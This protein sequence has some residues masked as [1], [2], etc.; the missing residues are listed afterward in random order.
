MLF[1][2]QKCLFM[3]CLKSVKVQDKDLL[4]IK[5][6]TP[7][8]SECLIPV[9]VALGAIGLLSLLTGLSPFKPLANFLK[10]LNWKSGLIFT[11]T[12]VG[13]V[14]V[15]SFPRCVKHRSGLPVKDLQKEI[16][17]PTSTI[18]SLPKGKRQP[19]V[20]ITSRENEKEFINSIMKKERRLSSK[21]LYRLHDSLHP[22][23]Q[24]TFRCRNATFTD[25]Q[26]DWFLPR[27][28]LSNPSASRC[29][30]Q[31]EREENPRCSGLISLYGAEAPGAEERRFYPAVW[32]KDQNHHDILTQGPLPQHLNEFWGMVWDANLSGVVQ[33]TE[34][35]E[36]GKEKSADYLPQT[37]SPCVY[38]DFT[39]SLID[40]ERVGE[41]D[42]V[43]SIEVRTLNI[44][45]KSGEE[46]QIKHVFIRKWAD[47]KGL[48]DY[49]E[50]FFQNMKACLRGAGAFLLKESAAFHCAAG[51]GRGPSCYSMV[52]LAR[53]YEHCRAKGETFQ[54]DTVTYIRDLRKQRA[55]AIQ[56]RAQG[57]MLKEWA[58]SLPN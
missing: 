1:F 26:G 48:Q 25:E 47:C 51:L 28:V 9:T 52:T 41:P 56:V 54:F 35:T 37:N 30:L 33:A 29:S 53:R 44:K 13:G 7:K 40:I 15:F 18:K 6:S 55:G 42:R 8:L 21:A 11:L 58:T 5:N 20:Q 34:P 46:R 10:P 4:F 14:L 22:S 27:S 12:S 24:K 36:R 2:E 49:Q 19:K 31:V 43:G 57:W 39:V 16:R 50:E 3:E 32:V 17:N 38:K 45:K 23:C